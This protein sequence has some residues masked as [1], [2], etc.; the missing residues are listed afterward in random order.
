[1]IN[2]V[3]EKNTFSKFAQSQLKISLNIHGILIIFIH[4]MQ[5]GQNL[6]IVKIINEILQQS[7]K[8][9]LTQSVGLGQ[10]LYPFISFMNHTN[11]SE[12]NFKKPF[13]AASYN[14]S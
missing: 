14:Y 6:N 5:K 9:C 12:A 7:L 2:S 4:A 10:I 11:H 13:T 1:L 3:I 8:Y